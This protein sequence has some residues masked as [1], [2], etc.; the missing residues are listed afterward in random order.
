MCEYAAGARTQIRTSF[1]DVGIESTPAP[2]PVRS[3]IASLTLSNAFIVARLVCPTSRWASLLRC[4]QLGFDP[5]SLEVAPSTPIE[6]AFRQLR[7]TD[8]YKTVRSSAA[9]TPHS[10]LVRHTVAVGRTF[11]R[12]HPRGSHTHDFA[13]GLRRHSTPAVLRTTHLCTPPERCW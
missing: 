10:S 1:L 6:E 5:S 3:H 13:T 7:A 4:P 12:T 11:S 2:E 8:T 9:P